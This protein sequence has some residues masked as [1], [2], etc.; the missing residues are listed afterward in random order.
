MTTA[1]MTASW[2]DGKRYWWLL[3]PALPLLVLVGLINFHINGA[4]FGAWGTPLIVYLIVPFLDLLIGADKTNPPDTAIMDLERDRYYRWIVYAYIPIQ[5]GVTIYGAWLAIQ[6]TTSWLA[7]VGLIFS[8][9]MING[10]GINT[11]HELGHKRENLERW[12]ARITL[13]PVAYGHFFV[14]HNRGHHRNVAT[15]EDPASSRMGESFWAFLPR[16]MIGSLRS[17]WSLERERLSRR[18]QGVWNRD[19]ENLQSWAM[20]VVLFGALAIW[21]GPKVLPFLLIQAF[22]GASLLE[23]VNYI[24]HYGLLRQKDANGRYV[25]CEPEHSWNNNHIMSNVFLYQL[26]RHSDHHAN[27]MRRFQALRHFENSPQL[28]VG[29]AGMLLPAYFPFFWYRLMDKRVIAHYRGDLAKANLQPSR[30][31]KLLRRYASA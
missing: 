21:L 26:Q 30:R 4:V 20:T 6:P 13:A 28:P 16:T 15:P 2:T 18:G 12:L 3:S 23:V 10:I 31:E 22:Y 1:T 24:E 5:Y 29:Y 25:R 11:A 27:P 9:G 17:A 14:E 8:V 19:N 7:F